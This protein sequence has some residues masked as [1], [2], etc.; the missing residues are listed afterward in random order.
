MFDSLKDALDF[1]RLLETPEA[2]VDF[3][4]KN[5]DKLE[6]WEVS[7]AGLALGKRRK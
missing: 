7:A 2:I 1:Y 6:G 3:V 4:N 5:G